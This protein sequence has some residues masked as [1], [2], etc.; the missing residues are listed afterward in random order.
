M[1]N[2]LKSLTFHLGDL[3]NHTLYPKRTSAACVYLGS[4]SLL[5]ADMEAK[6]KKGKPAS[7]L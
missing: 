1:A 5:V 6:A 3:P 4:M 7:K 2:G